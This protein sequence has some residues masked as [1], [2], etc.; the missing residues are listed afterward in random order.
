MLPNCLKGFPIPIV[1][2][3]KS[4]FTRLFAPTKLPNP[5]VFPG[6][7]VALVQTIENDSIVTP[8]LISL[9]GIGSLFSNLVQ[10]ERYYAILNM[11]RS[12]NTLLYH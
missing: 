9:G 4:I 11:T 2:G 6:K 8:S 10:H 5:K 12:N 7:T 1:S 3:F